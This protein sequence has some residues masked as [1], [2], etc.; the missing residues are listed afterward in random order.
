MAKGFDQVTVVYAGSTPIPSPIPTPPPIPTPEN[1]IEFTI[2]HMDH[3][4]NAV[5]EVTPNDVSGTIVLNDSGSVSYSIPLTSQMAIRAFSD[6]DLFDWM[7]VRNGVPLLAGPLE[8]VSPDTDNKSFLPVT[9]KTWEGYLAE[10]I[11]PWNP[12]ASN[13]DS[14]F[15]LYTDRDLLDIV[16]LL[17]DYVLGGPNSIPITYDPT[18]SGIITTQEFDPSSR[19]DLLSIIQGLAALQPGFDF[20]IDVDCQMNF[21][22]PHKGVIS[23]LVL[24]LDANAIQISYTD[25]RIR[26]NRISLQGSSSTGA[27]DIRVRDDLLSQ[28]ACR[29]RDVVDD[30]GTV[31][32][33]PEL[34]RHANDEI[35]LAV[36][37]QRDIVVRVD[38]QGSN[39]WEI[40]GVGDW[41]RVIGET[42]YEKLDDHFRCTQIDFEFTTESKEFLTYTFS[43]S[44]FGI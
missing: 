36:Q 8:S 17:S 28:A 22:T 38:P 41:I 32:S 24:E 6:P 35:V 37:K 33:I 10:R 9:G 5:G 7:L 13:V 15:K 25:N 23:D 18:D 21:Y 31:A 3:A 4:G 43:P 20:D 40:A 34:N 30:I 19:D 2:V 42:P 16:R 39:Y 27:T 29:I 1:D 14:Q 11:M 12:H 26:G 44:T